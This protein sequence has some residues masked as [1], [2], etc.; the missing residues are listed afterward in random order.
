MWL[1]WSNHRQSLREVKAGTEAIEAGTWSE[2][3]KQKPYWL[4]HYSLLRYIFILFLFI[5][6]YFILF[7]TFRTTCLEPALLTLE[8]SLPHQSLI[9]KIP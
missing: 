7:S 9:I 1:I 6:F 5:L 4:A 8:W 3:L 2:E